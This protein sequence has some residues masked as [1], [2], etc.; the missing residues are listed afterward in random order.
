MRRGTC[1]CPPLSS[2]EMWN[3][4]DRTIDG[5]DRTNN[6][7]EAADRKMYT[8]LGASHPIVWKFID[9]LKKIQKGRDL[10]YEQLVA[11]NA[12]RLNSLSM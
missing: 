8:E 11:G 3:Q 2:P 5:K 4:Y 9:G 10:Y 6:H 7:A 1:R 12:P